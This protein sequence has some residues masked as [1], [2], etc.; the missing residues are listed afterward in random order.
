MESSILNAIKNNLPSPETVISTISN[1]TNSTVNF[2]NA[3]NQANQNREDNHNSQV[4]QWLAIG[5]GLV[6]LASMIVFASYKQIRYG[7]DGRT[8]EKIY[9]EKDCCDSCWGCLGDCG[10]QLNHSN[11]VDGRFQVTENYQRREEYYTENEIYPTTQ[12]KSQKELLKERRDKRK[13]ELLGDCSPESIDE[14]MKI[15][16]QE[17]QERFEELDEKRYELNASEE[18]EFKILK[19]EKFQKDLEILLNLNSV[20]TSAETPNFPIQINQFANYNSISQ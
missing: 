10:D 8:Y 7:N 20:S 5:G 17:K 3:T 18:R 16:N 4:G 14:F 19:E 6:A 1:V 11:V 15:V 9:P 2:F 13:N 12:S